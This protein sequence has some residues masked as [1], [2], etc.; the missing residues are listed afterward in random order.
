MKAAV[1]GASGYLG[2]ELLR[3]LSGH[4]EIEVALAQAD[5]SAGKR[6]GDLYAGLSTG[7]PDLV[8]D[9]LDPHRA[10]GCDVA[11]IAVPSGHSQSIVASLLGRVGLVVDLGADFRLKDPTQYEQWYHFTHQ[12]PELLQ[13]AVFGLP[14][15]FRKSIVGAKLIASPGCYV[16]AASLALA[17]LVAAGAIE[18]SGIIVDAASGTSGAGKEPRP[19]LHYAKVNESFSAYG[20]LNHRHTPEIEQTIGAQILFTPHLA[21]MTRGILATCYA[22]PTAPTSTDVL[23]EILQAAYEGEPFI[24]VSEE[25]PSTRDTYGSNVVRLSARYDDRTNTVLLLSALD[26]LTKGGSGQALQATNIA[27]GLEETM[28][29]PRVALLP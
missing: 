11:F 8:L 19:D 6:P 13:E 1:I 9:P 16:T 18:K 12:Y 29:L 5:S 28:G 14:E 21:P 26:N 17:P 3:L 20:L 4:P 22:R 15:L 23:L 10:D 2:A 25:A 27:L 24:H 7:Y